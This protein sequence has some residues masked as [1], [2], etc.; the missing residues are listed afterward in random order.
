MNISWEDDSKEENR[1]PESSSNESKRFV[2][3]MAR[4]TSLLQGS[5]D[6]DSKLDED[7]DIHDFSNN[8]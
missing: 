1:E 4:S 5:S 8:E 2:A 6:K 7:L 3:F